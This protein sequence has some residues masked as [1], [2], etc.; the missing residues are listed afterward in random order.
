MDAFKCHPPRNYH[1]LPARRDERTSLPLR[2]HP[3]PRRARSLAAAAESMVD[4]PDATVPL[5]HHHPLRGR[6]SDLLGR[7][8]SSK[9]PSFAYN[10]SMQASSCNASRQPPEEPPAEEGAE[11]RP[12]VIKL[13]GYRDQLRELGASL[14]ADQYRSL[15]QLDLSRNAQNILPPWADLSQAPRSMLGATPSISHCER[16][17]WAADTSARRAA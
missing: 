6:T 5:P 3:V 10:A 4:L 15:T 12:D 1:P 14:L 8:E 16:T 7:L 2:R 13:S 17:I 11:R 9:Q